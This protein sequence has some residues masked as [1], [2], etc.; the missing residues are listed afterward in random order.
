M[1]SDLLEQAINNCSQETQKEVAEE[2]KNLI[3]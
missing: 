2:L 1:S 3:S